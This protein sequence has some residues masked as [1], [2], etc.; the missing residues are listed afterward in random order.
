MAQ[1]KVTSWLPMSHC[2]KVPL[3][4]IW[5]LHTFIRLE[6]TNMK[7]WHIKLRCDPILNCMLMIMKILTSFNCKQTPAFDRLTPLFRQPLTKG[8]WDGLVTLTAYI[9]AKIGIEEYL[10]DKFLKIHYQ[11]EDNLLRWK[12]M[13]NKSALIDWTYR[14][15]W[16]SGEEPQKVIC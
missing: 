4:Y 8:S 3:V 10:M 5:T 7:V 15:Y 12:V 14:T 2:L 11:L 9:A 6:K 1:K 13:P 16:N